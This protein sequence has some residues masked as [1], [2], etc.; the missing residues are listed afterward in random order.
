MILTIF[1]V[2]VAYDNY[3]NRLCIVVYL[4]YQNIVHHLRIKIKNWLKISIKK[5]SFLVKMIWFLSKY[6]IKIN[7]FLEPNYLYNFQNS[8]CYYS[9]RF[10]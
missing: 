4:S 8:T 2:N 7:D 5:G 1:G 10:Q 3:G 6:K 9:A